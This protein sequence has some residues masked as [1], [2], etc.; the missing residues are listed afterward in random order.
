LKTILKPENK[1]TEH[2]ECKIRSDAIKSRGKFNYLN[3]LHNISES[4][5]E[6]QDIK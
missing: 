6:K 4:M 5:P 1:I 3:V 2:V